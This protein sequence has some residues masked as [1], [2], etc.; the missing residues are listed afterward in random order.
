M[1]WLER[2]EVLRSLGATGNLWLLGEG[3]L[4]FFFFFSLQKYGPWEAPSALADGPT[5]LYILSGLSAPSELKK[6][7]KEM[8][9]KG[10]SG[11]GSKREASRGN[12]S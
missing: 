10:D 2:H 9:P 11:K 12:G 8:K 7:T 6:K 3:I 1:E 4:F 5:P